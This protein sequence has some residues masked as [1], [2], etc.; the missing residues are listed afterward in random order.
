MTI[1]AELTQNKFD[2]VKKNILKTIQNESQGEW[3]SLDD[4]ICALETE[5]IFVIDSEEDIS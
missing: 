4:I 1:K 2:Q 3:S 5:G